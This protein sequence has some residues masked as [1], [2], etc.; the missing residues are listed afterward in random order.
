M[1]SL[2][3]LVLVGG[4][5]AHLFVL[6]ALARRPAVGVEIVLVSPHPQATYTGMVPGVLGGQ[7]RLAQA[8]IDLVQLARRAQ[9]RLVLASAERIVADARCVRTAQGDI[10]YDLLSLDIGSQP[11][12]QNLIARGAQVAIVKPIENAV[13]AI[14][15]QLRRLA[16]GGG[17]VVI[18]GSG[19]GGV[20]IAFACAAR[21]RSGDGGRVTLLDHSRRPMSG[22]HPNT[23]DKVAELL[24]RHRIDFLGGV[25]VTA[26]ESNLVHCGK[27]AQ[28]AADAVVWATGAAA[29]TLLADSG[30]AR[31][32]RGF[33]LV[34]D[35]LRSTSDPHVF[36]AGDCIA[37]QSHPRLPKAGVYAVREG[38][39]LAHNL[40]AAL[41][42]ESLRSYAPQLD[43][44]ALINTG[45]GRAVFSRGPIAYHGRLAWW[46]KDRID[47]RF[48]SSFRG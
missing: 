30:L 4:G 12:A 1:S 6:R 18:V 25:E 2:R 27:Q 45:D 37:L 33:L 14:D 9:A 20:E 35:Q 34:D 44:L 21:L 36:G 19:A 5:H 29:P 47:R 7:Y 23:S 48:V 3:T 22:R 40:R 10:G 41:R 11:A 13:T 31:D 16:R 17:H 38:P 46:L 28:L 42:G 43:F 39:V 24:R 8:Q 32:E 15:A 26:V